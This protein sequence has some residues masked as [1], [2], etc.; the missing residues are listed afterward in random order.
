M[1]F[2]TADIFYLHLIFN[3]LIQVEAIE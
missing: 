2:Q 3:N 1:K